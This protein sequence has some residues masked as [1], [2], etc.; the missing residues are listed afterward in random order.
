VRHGETNPGVP[1]PLL[2]L[3]PIEALSLG[4]PPL[5]RELIE[6]RL[7]RNP[8]PEMREGRYDCAEGEAT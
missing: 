2:P 6:Q 7:I 5:L 1:L 8:S 4:G 3:L